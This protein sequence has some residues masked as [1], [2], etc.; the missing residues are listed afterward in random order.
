ML[1]RIVSSNPM[2]QTDTDLDGRLLATLARDWDMPDEFLV[3]QMLTEVDG[4]PTA[5]TDRKEDRSALPV[6]LNFTGGFPS[7]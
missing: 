4:S 7:L 2:K 5:T 6:V 3:E 1:P